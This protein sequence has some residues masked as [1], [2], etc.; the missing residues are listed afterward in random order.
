MKKLFLIKLTVPLEIITPQPE[1]PWHPPS[2]AVPDGSGPLKGAGGGWLMTSTGF[3]N[4]F[5]NQE[6]YRTN[7]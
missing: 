6:E 5:L 2:E 3:E 4:E 1:T 7:F